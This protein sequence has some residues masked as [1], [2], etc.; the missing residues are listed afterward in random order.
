MAED[1]TR[2]DFIFIAAGGVAAFGAAA[3]AVP[4]IGSMN[5]GADV[6]SG[7]DVDLSQHFFCSQPRSL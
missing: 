4:L 3:L 7:L 2:R 5:P 1:A 6:Q